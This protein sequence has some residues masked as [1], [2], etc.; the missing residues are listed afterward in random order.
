MAGPRRPLTPDDFQTAS[1]Q[2]QH[3]LNGQG[4]GQ[5]AL[6]TK[7]LDSGEEGRHDPRRQCPCVAAQESRG[8]A[9]APP[10][11]TR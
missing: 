1:R 4:Q 5:S 11:L 3:N 2:S 8:N 6:L 9:T 10:V 7:T